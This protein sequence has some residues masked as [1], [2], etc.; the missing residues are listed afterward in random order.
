MRKYLKFASAGLA[1]IGLIMMFFTQITVKWS[2]YGHTESFG[3]KALVGGST[4]YAAN[5]DGVTSGLVGYILLGVGALLVLLTALVAYFAEHEILSSV[6][7]GAGVICMIVGTILIFLIRKNATDII[8]AETIFVGW[9]AM[10]GGSLGSLGAATGVLSV[11][12]D[13]AK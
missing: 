12:L 11:I 1:I 3:L 4:K 6:V 7:T 5:I 2:E 13:L 10:V 9:G 8:E